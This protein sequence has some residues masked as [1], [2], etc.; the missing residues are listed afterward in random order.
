MPRKLVFIIIGVVILILII[1]VVVSTRRRATPTEAP[2]TPAP[3]LTEEEQ[4]LIP[5]EERVT[6]PEA[7]KIAGRL[8][9]EK[10]LDIQTQAPTQAAEGDNI[11][12]FDQKAGEF[13]IA[14]TRGTNVEPLTQA[15][16]TNVEEVVWSPKKDKA[17]IVFP[18]EK[19]TY[20]LVEKS[21]AKLDEHI[22]TAT[23][24]PDSTKILYKFDSDDSHI[25]STAE[26]DGS[27]W[28]K[29]KDVGSGNLVLHWYKADRIAY[30]S[31]ASGH[32]RT[33]IYT[34]NLEGKDI[35]VIASDNYGSNAKWSPDALK[36]IFTT[37]PK[38]SSAL[39]LKLAWGDGSNIRDL[40]MYTLVEKCAFFQDSKSLYCALPEPIST[41]F[42]LPDDWYDKKVITS[43]SFWKIDTE[44]GERTK[45][46]STDD[47]E[48]L[49]GKTFDAS[50]LFVSQDG[51]RLFFT[52]RNDGKLYNISIP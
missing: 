6:P 16:F 21:S 32:S 27:N 18:E 31:P 24:S 43:D 33:T 7:E 47:I 22:T 48:T 45:I 8:M 13:Y 3:P 42:V 44:T 28:K 14:S 36:M 49:Y 50:N 39:A 30:H 11:V 2:V 46:A 19:H 9:I 10:T 5:A 17:I 15:G 35:K 1:V 12:Y 25:L 40:G 4:R 29:I 23:F 20:D 52:A 34:C 38:E 26:P 51:T 41:R 37:S